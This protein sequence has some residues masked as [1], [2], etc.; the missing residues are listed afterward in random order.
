MYIHTDICV[1]NGCYLEHTSSSFSSTFTFLLLMVGKFYRKIYVFFM[2]REQN[3]ELFSF[4]FTDKGTKRRKVCR[5]LF[6]NIF[7]GT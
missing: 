6:I 2:K 4:F 7:H 1:M 5:N 3:K